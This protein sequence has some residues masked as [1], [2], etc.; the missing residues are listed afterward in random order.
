[1][2][3][4]KIEFQC[5]G[6]GCDS[7]VVFSVGDVEQ[8]GSVSCVTCKK[9]YSFHPEF[10][11]KMRKFSRLIEAVQDAKDILGD[12]NVA[13]KVKNQ[14]IKVPY[15]LLLTRMNTLITLKMEDGEMCFRFRVEPLNEQ[16]II[17]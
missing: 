9:K 8:N 15:R 7:V 14:E 4:S 1:M 2:N 5:I 13:I 17:K 6:T 10:V 11:S 16:E 3:H 12:T